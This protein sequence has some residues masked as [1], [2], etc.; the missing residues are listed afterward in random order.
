MKK[1][2]G[3]RIAGFLAAAALAVTTIGTPLVDPLNA[4]AEGEASSALDIESPVFS[5]DNTETNHTGSGANTIKAQINFTDGS[6]AAITPEND[7]YNYYLLVHAKGKDSN[8]GGYT[9]NEGESKDHYQLVK[10]GTNNS[11]WTSDTFNVLPTGRGNNT[12]QPPDT[13]LLEGTVIRS[14]VDWLSIDTMKNG[15]QTDWCS[16]QEVNDVDGLDI[17]D[18]ELKDTNNDGNGDTIVMNASYSFEVNVDVYDFDGETPDKVDTTPN[19]RYYVLTMLV[20]S[21]E[22]GALGWGLKEFDPK[23]NSK[24]KITFGKFHNFSNDE[25]YVSYDPSAGHSIITR[26]LRSSVEL[27]TLDDYIENGDKIDANV[28][29]FKF[30]K[31]DDDRHYNV[32]LVRSIVDYTV[33]ITCDDDIELPADNYYYLLVK[34]EHA[35]TGYTYYLEKIDIS[36]EKSHV[37]NIQS[38]ESAS[39]KD[40]NGNLLESERYNGTEKGIEIMLLAAGGEINLNSAAECAN[41]GRSV[42]YDGDFINGYK[43]SY[44]EQT[45][46]EVEDTKNGKKVKVNMIADHIVLEKVDTTDDYNFKSILGDGLY[47]GLTADRFQQNN[48]AQTNF[49]V[50]YY[51]PDGNIDQDLSGDFG[52]HIYISNF[53]NFNNKTV[54][55]SDTKYYTKEDASK[56]HKK[57][58]G[59]DPLATVN[60]GDSHLEKGTVLHV[61]STDRL[62]EKSGRD[63]VAFVIE[64]PSAM[65][66]NTIE[67]IINHM[68]D[69]SEKLLAHK[70]NIE[71]FD[72]SSS[73]FIIID[74]RNYDDDATVYVDGDDLAKKLGNVID[75]E[76]IKFRIKP[77]QT[78]VVNFKNTTDKLTV[79]E[80]DA[81]IYD[82]EG[83]L[84]QK[85]DTKPNSA[86]GAQNEWLD[87][88]I[89]RQIVWNLANVMDLEIKNT[90]GIFLIPEEDSVTDL[91]GS[92]SGWLITDGYIINHAE[93]HYLYD[94]LPTSTTDIN[95]TKTDITGR[96]EVEGAVLT[97]TD[98]K[99]NVYQKWTTEKNEA[100]TVQRSFKLAPGK[101][102]LTE[103]G[104]ET[105]EEAGT[106]KPKEYKVI[107]TTVS[108]EVVETTVKAKKYD[109]EKQEYVE[110]DI[111]AAKVVIDD[112]Q[113]GFTQD[114]ANGFFTKVNAN[115]IR[116]NDAEKTEETQEVTTDVT[117]SKTAVNGQ[118][119]LENAELTVFEGTGTD[120]IAKDVDDNEITW[121]SDGKAKTFTL[122]PGTYTF[123]ETG[124]PFTSNGVNYKVTESYITFTIAADGTITVDDAKTANDGGQ[125]SYDLNTKVMT[126]SDAQTS[127]TNVVLS[128]VDIAGEEIAGAIIEIYEKGATEAKYHWISTKNN[129]TV[130]TNVFELQDGEYILKEYSDDNNKYG[131]FTGADGKNYKIT[132]SVVNFTVYDGKVTVSDDENVSDITR[133]GNKFTIEDAYTDD[134]VVKVSKTDITG[135]T[136]LA[137]AEITIFEGEAGSEVIAK[138]AKTGEELKWVSD[139]TAKS[140]TLKDGGYTIKETGG[141]FKDETTG[142]NYKVV[143]ASVG[144]TVVNG[145]VDLADSYEDANGKIEIDTE[146]KTIT[147]SDAETSE[148]EVKISKTDINGEKELEGA[149]LTIK[150]SD[151]KVVDSWESNGKAKTVTLKDGTYTLEET[152]SEFEDN[153]VTYKVTTSTVTFTVSDGKVVSHDVKEGVDG[154][155]TVDGNKITVSDAEKVEEVVVED[156]DVTISKTDIT[157]EKELTGAELTIKDS[158]GKV[159]E[160]WTSDGTEKTVTLKDGTYTLEETGSE[161]E[162]NGVTYKVTTSTVTF[163][164]S[165][166]KVVSHDV[167]EGV[168]GKITVDGNKITVSD[169]EAEDGGD[170]EKTDGGDDEKTD[171][172]DDEKTD[173]GDDE[174]TDGGDDEKTDGGDDEQTEDGGDEETEDGGDEQTEDGGDEESDGDEDEDG[175]EDSDED[176]DGDEDSDEDEDSD[177]EKD[178]DGDSGSDSDSDKNDGSGSGSASTNDG[179][180]DSSN[181]SSGSGSGSGS[182][183]ADGSGSGSASSTGNPTTG[184]GS[185]PVALVLAAGTIVLLKKKKDD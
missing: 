49:A 150:D 103:E 5:F 134:T 4:I 107:K 160:K 9:Y 22:Q 78:V 163:T 51:Q 25:E 112:T 57:E 140:V 155:I 23:N 169:A 126:I 62:R 127:K 143:T 76:K 63:F 94:G 113:K 147:I 129:G 173:G 125:V 111:P 110:V 38:A 153:G 149:E 37:F 145:Y 178:S 73:G 185:F 90:A 84:I 184:N 82:S 10:I 40:G 14:N 1:P 121:V 81:E 42:L 89:T 148:T 52:G 92:S 144:F 152:G 13:M 75:G 58:E 19:D 120:K 167:K 122:K 68:D 7:G 131:Y 182:G 20:G 91:T 183:S 44:G 96:T 166:G 157:G 50:N 151:G 137:G 99:G 33:D 164:V 176:E 177:D 174:K 55:D 18:F 24:S 54:V 56:Y 72:E 3:K 115:T 161:F 35:N 29:G 119:E 86:K 79:G 102:I 142:K 130:V 98:E 108:F 97:I 162:D 88:Y 66:N 179:D 101:Y 45:K 156:T 17:T 123:K 80:F 39:W 154:K 93:W 104:F 83:N 171:D 27:K 32:K 109:S 16:W 46:T 95:I 116:V 47:V 53:V 64:E 117:F 41:S 36:G 138:D 85:G 159:V 65:T 8:W 165:D 28:P 70:A 11:T 170:D 158:D 105:P 141:S 21:E 146:K 34:V 69:V 135:K 124:K 77:G 175:D 26:I 43:I 59:A 48:H 181:G 30:S 2:I 74:A 133:E 139:G 60:I 106:T 31:T 128:K 168:D 6:G 172:G 87:K 118:A 136:E 100:G 114:T 12:Q 61:D 180:T 15:I 132:D 67:P 71:V